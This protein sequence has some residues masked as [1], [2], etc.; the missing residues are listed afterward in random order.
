MNISRGRAP[1]IE[2]V[3]V[4]SKSLAGK[5]KP[6]SNKPVI[7]QGDSGNALVRD[8]SLGFPCAIGAPDVFVRI[9][10]VIEFISE[11]ID[12]SL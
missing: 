6:K 1:I 11:C 10:G 9:S 4:D 7:F 5:L 8:G 2:P 12:K 3:R